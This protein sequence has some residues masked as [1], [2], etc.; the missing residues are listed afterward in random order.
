MINYKLYYNNFQCIIYNICSIFFII[1]NSLIPVYSNEIIFFNSKIIETTAIYYLLD[2]EKKRTN[3]INFMN[4][5]IEKNK[6][7]IL[8]LQ[9]DE[10]INNYK[11]DSNDEYS[12]SSSESSSD[13]LISQSNNLSEFDNKKKNITNNDSSSEI[14]SELVNYRHSNINNESSYTNLFKLDK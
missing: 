10:D 1:A 11:L 12:S 3:F 2:S 7:Y 4:N 9:K 6:D 8:T 5:L 14:L 13:D